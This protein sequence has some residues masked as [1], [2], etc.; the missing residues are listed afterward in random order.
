M[1]K[2]IESAYIQRILD[3][4][5][6]LFSIFVDNHSPSVYSLIAQI[7]TSKED[8]EELTQDVFVKA[9]E[10]LKTFKGDCSFST[11]IYRIAYNTAISHVRKKR[12]VFPFMDES[13]LENIEDETV[14]AFFEDENE[15]RIRQLGNAIDRLNIEERT[16]ITLFYSNDKSI[17][18]IALILDLSIENVKVRLF[19]VRKKLFKLMTE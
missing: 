4:E 14:D 17:S 11:W 9:F 6:K 10:K 8:A 19:R 13:L 7:I 5:T 1:E 12:I 16:L 2:Q 15:T 3:G 18:E